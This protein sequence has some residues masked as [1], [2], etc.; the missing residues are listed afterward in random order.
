[1]QS[2]EAPREIE[3][4]VRFDERDFVTTHR[5]IA[6]FRRTMIASSVVGVAVVLGGGGC[7]LAS[8]SQLR[9][10]GF[11]A[12]VM[13]GAGIFL[14]WKARTRG[15]REW[16]SVRDW[17]ARVRYRFSS[18]GL[19]SENEKEGSDQSWDLF[20]GWSEGESAFYL[21]QAGQRFIIVPKRAFDGEEAIEAVRSLLRE[22]VRPRPGFRLPL[23][24]PMLTLGL[25]VVLIVMFVVIYQLVVSGEPPPDVPM[26]QVHQGAE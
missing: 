7:L 24:I 16:R 3:A 21:E 20:A 18:T 4:Q 12:L 15:S 22:N 9:I 2:E 26:D 25:W 5:E 17:Q 23:P 10:A 13:I 6:F 19:R 1:M 8:L 11:G 14:V